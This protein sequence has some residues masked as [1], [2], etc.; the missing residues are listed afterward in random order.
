MSVGSWAGTTVWYYLVSYVLGSRLRFVQA[1]AVSGYGL[2]GWVLALI[3]GQL[4]LLARQ[5]GIGLGLWGVVGDATWRPS[6]TMSLEVPMM[7]FGIPSGSSMGLV[8]SHYT[9]ARERGGGGAFGRSYPFT[10]YVR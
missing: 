7:V 1:L 4:M 8:F 9:P 2:F 10:E 3:V 6:I 5:N